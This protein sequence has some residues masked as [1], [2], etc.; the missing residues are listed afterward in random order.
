MS[1]HL[2]LQETRNVIQLSNQDEVTLTNQLTG[3]IHRLVK[4]GVSPFCN[5]YCR[6]LS[7]YERLCCGGNYLRNGNI[8]DSTALA[9][10]LPET[11][12]SFL[13]LVRVSEYWKDIAG[14][15]KWMPLPS[16]VHTERQSQPNRCGSVIQPKR[17]FGIGMRTNL[18]SKEML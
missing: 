5:W 3:G 16:R 11:Y 9:V 4:L 15:C 6:A 8:R 13:Q 12:K 7:L 17:G 10:P 1:L 14:C 18:W 2:L